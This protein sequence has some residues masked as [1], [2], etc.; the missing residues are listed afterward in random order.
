[1]NAQAAPR[2]LAFR[3]MSPDDIDAVLAI[4]RRA[5]A[6]PWTR[7]NFRDCLESGYSCWVAEEGGELIGYSILMTGAEEG[8]VLNC[9]IAPERQGHGHGRRL[10]LRLIDGLPELAVH[11]LFLEVRPSNAAAIKL[12]ASL[13]FETVGLRRHYYPAEAGRED[14]L[15][16]RYCP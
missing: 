11:C 10:M 7:G 3:P 1:M 15:V 5:Y 8:H 12:Y 16:M 6:F 14:A 9:C 2:P 4:E 13:G